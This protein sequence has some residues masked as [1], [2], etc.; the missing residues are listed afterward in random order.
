MIRGG[1]TSSALAELP[2]HPRGTAAEVEDGDDFGGV[3][4][5]P[6]EDTE[7]KVWNQHTEIAESFGMGAVISR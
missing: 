4:E 2:P 5:F 7:W 1:M 3:R 6:V